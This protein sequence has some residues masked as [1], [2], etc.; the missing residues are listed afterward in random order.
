MTQSD[1]L[2]RI[3]TLLEADVTLRASERGMML[4]K[5]SDMAADVKAI[6][7]DMAE[8]KAELSADKADLAAL[9]NKG[10]GLLV[11]AAIAGGAGWEAVKALIGSV[12]K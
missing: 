11:G 1:R 6:K 12:F 4:E 8:V 7:D 5:F 3:E 10:T 2:T 9:K